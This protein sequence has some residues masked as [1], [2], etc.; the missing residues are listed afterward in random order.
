MKVTGVG[1]SYSS[2]GTRRTERKDRHGGFSSLLGTE[3]T[4]ETRAVDIAQPLA[5]VDALLAVQSVDAVDEREARR[6]AAQQG[7]ALLDGLEE[8][9]MGLLTGALPKERLVELSRMVRS[10]REGVSDPRL[11][12]LLDEIELRVEV[13]LAKLE[14]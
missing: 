10:R 12:Q 13:E 2:A 1:S 7:A 14:R 9:R 3:E 5:G 11:S 8:I 4:A 6:R